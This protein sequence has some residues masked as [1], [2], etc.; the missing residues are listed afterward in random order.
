MH[1]N[2][3]GPKLL[4]WN[5]FSNLSAIYTKWCAQLFRRFLN[6]PKRRKACPNRPINGKAMLVRTS[7]LRTHGS[8][9]SEREKQQKN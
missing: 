7:T 4:Q 9:D 1:I 2:V 6:F 5:F 3:L 8:P